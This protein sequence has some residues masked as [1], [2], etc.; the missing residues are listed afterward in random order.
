MKTVSRTV[1][2]WKDAGNFRK[3]KWF[4]FQEAVK[5]HQEFVLAEVMRPIYR[6]MGQTT[7]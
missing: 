4:A 7:W 1:S 5:A 6:K 3:T 2:I